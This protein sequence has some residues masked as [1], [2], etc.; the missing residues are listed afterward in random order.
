MGT[1]EETLT[2]TGASPIVD[3]QNVVSQNVLSRDRI[4]ALPASQAIA[5]LAALTLGVTPSA[6]SGSFSDV[7]GNKGEQI[8]SMAVH[9]GHQAD[10]ISMIDGMSMQQ[11]SLQARDS[12]ACSS[13]TS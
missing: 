6:S 3:V 8:A 7:G 2:V 5:G 10:Q 12:S 9:G 4:D 11:R 1:V 13:T